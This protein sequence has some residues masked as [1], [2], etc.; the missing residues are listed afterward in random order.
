MW[1]VNFMCQFDWTKGYPDSCEVLFLGVS[2]RVS[3]KRL[4]FELVNQVKQT[5]LS[6]VRGH[7]P[8]PDPIH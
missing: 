1:T 3:L 2:L 5:A 6:N 7:D 8:W 4:A